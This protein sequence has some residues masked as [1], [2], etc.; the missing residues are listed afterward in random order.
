M[1]TY[2]EQYG[3]YGVMAEF[4]DSETLLHAAKEAYAAGYRNMDAYAPMPVEGLADAIGFRKH[5][6]SQA[7]LA[8]GILGG[9]GGFGLM[10]WIS[11][12][13]YPFNVAGRPMNSWPAYIP[14]TFECTVL[15]ASLTAVIGMFAMNGLP[16]PYHPVFNVPAFARAS[17]D[18][19]FLCIE[20]D[21]PQF[22]REETKLFLERLGPLEVT[23]VEK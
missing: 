19:F 12:I 20:V 7:V 1:G 17:V 9:C 23:E 4:P 16:M 14:I 10:Y 3:L 22:D 21:D 11:V 2:W 18:R 15:L 6:V 5:W 8:A 13:A